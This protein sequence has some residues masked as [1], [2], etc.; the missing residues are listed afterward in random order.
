MKETLIQMMTYTTNNTVA[1]QQ[2]KFPI[3]PQTGLA[4]V[5]KTAKI[6]VLC[7]GASSERAVS[8]RSGKNCIA[9]L[10][11]LGYNNAVLVEVDRYIAHYLVDSA[12][13]VAYIAMHGEQG[14]DGAIQ[15]LMEIL[16][17]PYTGNGIQANAITMDKSRTKQVLRESGIAVLPSLTFYWSAEE[18]GDLTFM[19]RLMQEVGFPMMVKPVGTGSS[20]GMSKVDSPD[21]LADALDEASGYSGGQ[22]MAER[23]AVGKDLTVGTLLLNGRLQVTPILEIRPKSGWY[24][25]EA[26]YTA[27]M[28]DFILPAE[29]TAME[30]LAVQE[31]A[32]KA[33]KAVG[34]H[35]VSRTDFVWTTE[36]YFVLEINSIPGMT[37]L[38][39]L[40]A[41][42][43]VMGLGY[44]E[45]VE[46]LLQSAV[47]A[48]AQVA[49][50]A[51]HPIHALSEIQQNLKTASVPATVSV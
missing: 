32:L 19:D 28:T 33:H 43:R 22:V 23:F 50:V 44:D 27:G 18:G 46:A 51:P 42:C 26:K 5:P 31:M 48:P 12:I 29:L 11:R 7:G 34:C 1:P 15:G 30:T 41:Q 10:H 8:L 36:G 35:G 20:V 38:S 49:T 25:Y 47:V 24:D 13:E 17:I 9:A 37:D 21:K 2:E 6:A 14:E 40:P 3:N 45:L 4:F 16:G 39:D